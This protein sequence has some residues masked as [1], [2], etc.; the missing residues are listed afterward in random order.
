M[1]GG[2]DAVSEFWL[3]LSAGLQRHHADHRLAC[4]RGMRRQLVWKGEVSTT[5]RQSPADYAGMYL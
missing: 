5:R 3:L 2:F 4:S 1:L